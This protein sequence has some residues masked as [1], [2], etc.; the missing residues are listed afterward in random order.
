MAKKF[1]AFLC[2]VLFVG[3]GGFTKGKPAAE[4]A[5]VQFHNL[6]N[7]GKLDD[8]WKEANQQFRTA[9]PKEKYNEFMGAVQRKLGKVT[10]TT[11]AGWNVKSFNLKTTVYL[12]Q[13]TAF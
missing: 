5:V 11:N 12:T 8:I 7:E 2:A 3:C 6:Y 4:R 9:S 13:Q 1:I 10:G